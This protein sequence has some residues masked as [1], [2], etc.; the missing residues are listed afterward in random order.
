[1]KNIKTIHLIAIITI[2]DC[3]CSHGMGASLLLWV[4][5]GVYKAT[6]KCQTKEQNIVG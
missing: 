3:I 4:G 6:I 5:Y 2:V 1:M